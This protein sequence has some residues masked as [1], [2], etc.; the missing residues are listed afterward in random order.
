M[1]DRLAAFTQ[2]IFAAGRESNET[3]GCFER[4]RVAVAEAYCANEFPPSSG[5]FGIKAGDSKHPSVKQ[6]YVM[7][8]YQDCLEGAVASAAEWA[9]GAVAELLRMLRANGIGLLHSLEMPEGLTYGAY[10]GPIRLLVAYYINS[11]SYWFRIDAL[12]EPNG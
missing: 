3:D 2:R 7:E 5:R 4:F 12:G 1:D 11:D 8:E 6:F 9:P 10:A